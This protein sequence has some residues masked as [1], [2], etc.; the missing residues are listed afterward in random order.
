M[1]K[2]TR[3]VGFCTLVY[4]LQ[5]LAI[6]GLGGDEDFCWTEESDPSPYTRVRGMEDVSKM[7]QHS[8]IEKPFIHAKPHLFSQKK[9]DPNPHPPHLLIQSE[10]PNPDVPN[11]F[12]SGVVSHNHSVQE[13]RFLSPFIYLFKCPILSPFT[14]LFVP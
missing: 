4:V 7:A 8:M 1:E 5:P 9:K 3:K 10:V 11:L 6:W 2:E 13:V 12:Q 14:Y